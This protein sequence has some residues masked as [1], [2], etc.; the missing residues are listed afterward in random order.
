M[1][2]P[3][4]VQSFLSPR[5]QSF[6]WSALG[7]VTGILCKVKKDNSSWIEKTSGGHR[8]TLVWGSGERDRGKR[9]DGKYK[10]EEL[11]LSS[12]VRLW[13]LS[14][15]PVDGGSST[16]LLPTLQPLASHCLYTLSSEDRGSLWKPAVGYWLLFF[17]PG[18]AVPIL[19]KVL[20]LEWRNSHSTSVVPFSCF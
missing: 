11:S 7:P 3:S 6:Q 16:C 4:A 17:L 20:R 10:M 18:S 14:S 12:F 15:I 8:D 19:F 9:V 13:H 5:S 1:S 2:I